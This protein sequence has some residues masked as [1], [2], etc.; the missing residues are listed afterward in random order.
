MIRIVIW[1]L[2]IMI[3][4][5]GCLNKPD[6]RSTEALDKESELI[7]YNKSLLS[8]DRTLITEFAEETGL[9]VRETSTGLWYLET[10]GGE[11]PEIKLGDNVKFD[12]ECTLLSGVRC[13]S[14]TTSLMVGYADAASGVTEGLQM[15]RPGSEFLFIIPPYLAFGLTG[16]GN[17]IPGRSILIYKIRI[18]EVV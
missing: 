14:G 15:M 16:D 8:K 9:A 4:L 1:S 12:F 7:E 2:M 10:K 3:F 5:S 18:K 11:G 13:Y 6:N 17:K